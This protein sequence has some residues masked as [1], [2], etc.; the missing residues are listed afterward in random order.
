MGESQ[1]VLIDHFSSCRKSPMISASTFGF[2]YTIT[3]R[4]MIFIRLL[5]P[6]PGTPQRQL[7]CLAEEY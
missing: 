6:C 7:P 5:N 2:R 1:A 3:I 4:L